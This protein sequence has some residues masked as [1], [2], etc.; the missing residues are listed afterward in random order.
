MITSTFIKIQILVL[1]IDIVAFITKNLTHVQGTGKT[2][3]L[4]KFLS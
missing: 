4:K 3:N 1:D 2:G